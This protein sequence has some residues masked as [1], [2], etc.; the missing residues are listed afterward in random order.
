VANLF[1]EGLFA[2]K[3]V[4]PPEFIGKHKG[5]FEYVLAYLKE[6]NVIYRKEVL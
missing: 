1:L 2:E 6:R 5:C 4:F 3:G